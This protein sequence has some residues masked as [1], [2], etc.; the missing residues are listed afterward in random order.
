VH[1]MQTALWRR[2]T[3]REVNW[4]EKGRTFPHVWGGVRWWLYGG[5]RRKEYSKTEKKKQFPLSPASSGAKKQS[6][7]SGERSLN[8]KKGRVY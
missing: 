5:P 8:T 2:A 7:E 3:L 4:T 1:R 6:L